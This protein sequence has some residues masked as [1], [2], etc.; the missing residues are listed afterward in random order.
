[1]PSNNFAPFAMDSNNPKWIGSIVREETLYGRKDD[2]RSESA[3]DYNRILHCTAYRRL[4][5][6][7]QVFF[8]TKND[9]IC[10]RIEH[11]NHVVSISYTVA[12]FL[13]L[14]T[15]LTN[16]IALGHDLGHAPFGHEGENILSDLAKTKLGMT[17][18]HEQNSLKFIDKIETL[19]DPERNERNLNLT[20][21]VRDGIVSHCGEVNENGIFPREDS[22][23]LWAIKKPGEFSPYSWEGCIVK[24]SDKISFLGRDVEDSLT[25]QLLNYSE[26]RELI[27]II[28]S[29]Y[30]VPLKEINNTVIIHEL[31]INLCTSSTP[32]SGIT[33]SNDYYK[34]IKALSTFS[35]SKIYSHPRLDNFK[36]YARLVLESI[37]LALSEIYDGPNTP[38]KIKRY[39]K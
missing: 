22:I 32:E 19:Q 14:N 5:H 6:K 35:Y 11:V 38:A 30:N 15:E 9:H 8:A 13:G 37:F 12:K 7:T 29:T 36:K 21:A 39:E 25:L 24:V 20:Y 34:F 4:K 10:T 18:W 31:I 33:F 28:R 16:A 1:M 26:L 23:D 17:F 3:R 2:I 27:R